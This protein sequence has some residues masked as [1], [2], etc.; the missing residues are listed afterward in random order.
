MEEEEVLEG[1]DGFLEEGIPY[2]LPGHTVSVQADVIILTLDVKNVKPGSFVKQVKPSNMAVAFKFSSIGAGYVEIHHAFAIDFLIAGALQEDALDVEF[3]DNN[4]IVSLPMLTGVEGYKAG[5]SLHNLEEKIVSLGQ[6]K[7]AE[8]EPKS[9][10]RKGGKYKQEKHPK[11]MPQEEQDAEQEFH[12]RR[13]E[14]H[15]S[16]DSLDS[17]MSESPMESVI[18]KL[19]KEEEDEASEKTEESCDEEVRLETPRYQRANSEDSTQAQPRGILKRKISGLVGTSRFRCYSE[20]H[21]DEVGF[22]TSSSPSLSTTTISEDQVAEF[23][24]SGKK[25]VRFNEKVQQQMYRVNSTILAN[26]LKNKRKAEKKKRALERRMS[27]G[28][29]CSLEQANDK[30]DK[31]DKGKMSTSSS[32]DLNMVIN[33]KDQWESEEHEDSGL[34]SSFE[35]HL[36]LTGDNAAPGKTKAKKMTKKR[37]KQFVMSNE[38]IFDL[39]I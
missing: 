38:L 13:K 15:G 25:S 37:S 16:G 6:V 18:L 22:A 29:A 12:N 33:N 9:K 36:V 1:R 39:D 21:L 23:S 11:V 27:E 8:V 20:S 2:S 4:V 3:W 30:V 10:K 7:M 35:E 31:V 32:L 5:L 17:C 28:D 14:R 19:A 24:G 34:A 26:T